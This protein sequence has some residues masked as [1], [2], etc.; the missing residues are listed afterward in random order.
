M[1]VLMVTEVPPHLPAHDPARLAPAYLLT[2]LAKRHRIALNTPEVPADTPAQRAW[3]TSLAAVTR[4]PLTRWRQPFTGAPAEGL[5]AVRAVALK[6]VAEW[7]PDVVHLEGMLLAPLAAALPVPAVVGCRESAVRRARDA[8]RLATSPHDWVRAQL[9]ERRDTEW[10]QRWLPAARGIVVGSEADRGI[11]AERVP[12]ARIDVVPG[13]VDETRY[14]FRRGGEPTRL[15]FA[16]NL[17]RPTH[18]DAARRLA[19]R[20]LPLVR[21]ALPSAELLVVGGGPAAALR[22]LAQTP[23]V[24][25]AG[26]TADLR[27]SIWSAS[28]LLVP[29][30]ATPGVEAAVLEAMALGTPVII[31]SR[32]LSGLV[33]VLPG[34]HVL[35]AETD[36][37]L[38]EA[39][40]LVLREPVVATTLA[41]NARQML[42]RRYTWS[43]VARAYT[44]LWARAVDAAPATVAA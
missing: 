13:G 26:A 36:A 32:T 9:D 5:A 24:R 29:A 17:A 38:A 28:A 7:R 15:V 10:E 39:A 30:E 20:V 31:S 37:E 40:V 34:Q 33:H 21:R 27:P 3:P 11:V 14:E 19:L 23:G 6:A 42:E 4:V 1:R 35:V 43:A 44:A 18:R 22:A 16:G 41:A 25:V 12:F 2:H 8:R